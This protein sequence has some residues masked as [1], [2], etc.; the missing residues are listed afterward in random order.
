ML[1]DNVFGDS[2][3]KL[4]QKIIDYGEPDFQGFEKIRGRCDILYGV[5]ILIKR[6]CDLNTPCIGHL[7]ASR[8]IS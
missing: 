2:L 8:L 4:G 7:M 5:K 6:I 1:N 3:G